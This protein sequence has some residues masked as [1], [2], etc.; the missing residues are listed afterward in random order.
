MGRV[1]SVCFPAGENQGRVNMVGFSHGTKLGND[2][3]N[4][5]TK[6]RELYALAAIVVV[7]AILRLVDLG[8]DSMWYDEM[9]ITNNARTARS[10]RELLA[11]VET[12]RGAAPSA[13]YGVGSAGLCMS[14]NSQ[15]VAAGRSWKNCL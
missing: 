1:N 9:V 7:A 5:R 10:L 3:N 15:S 2:A 6:A 12:F 8:Y 14:S 13:R 11:R 4:E